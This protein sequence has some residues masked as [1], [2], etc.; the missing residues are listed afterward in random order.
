MFKKF[1][2][3]GA[4][5]LTMAT[6]STIAADTSRFRILLPISATTPSMD[7]GY[8]ADSLS[9]S[10]FGA[11]YI[12]G[13]G[14][15]IGYT[16]H[17]YDFKYTQ[18]AAG[19]DPEYKIENSWTNT[20]LELSYTFGSELTGQVFYAHQLSQTDIELS[21]S[22]GGSSGSYTMEEDGSSGNAYGIIG[23]YDFG[24]FEALLGYRSEQNTSKYIN[25][26]TATEDK[27]DRTII[28]AGIGF[29]F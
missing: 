25:L 27:R 8:K 12:M 9:P 22:G 10:G 29:T 21:W 13:S 17:K 7:A 19:S 1:L 11:H 26:G 2:F 15:G 5:A 20:Y 18:E 28:N 4:A 24:G 14:L 3:L 16:S 23:G 6:T